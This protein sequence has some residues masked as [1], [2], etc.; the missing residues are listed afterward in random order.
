MTYDPDDMS[1]IYG[2]A[3]RFLKSTLGRWRSQLPELWEDAYQEG[4]IQVWRDVEAGVSPKLKILR[5]A[6]MASERFLH[7]NGENF[8]GRQRKSREGISRNSGTREKVEIFLEEY[9]PVHGWVYPASK[10]V[11]EAI[12]ITRENA[13]QHLKNIREGRGDHMVYRADGRMDWNY[14]KTHSIE[15]LMTSTSSSGTSNRH[16]SDSSEVER[17]QFSWEA[18]LIADVDVLEMLKKLTPAHQEILY[19]HLFEGYT[20]TEVARLNGVEKNPNSIGG[21]TLRAALN[22]IRMLIAPYEGECSVGHKRSPETSVVK[23]RVDGFY[24]RICTVC[25]KNGGGDKSLV[26]KKPMGRKIKT[27]CPKGHLKD[28]VDSHGRFRC[29]QCRAEAQRRYTAKKRAQDDSSE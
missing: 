29:S 14:Y 21:K 27:H 24:I 25:R 7:R 22:Q 4:M 9:M 10:V 1:N 20:A 5:R 28:Q 2:E 11:A 8:F 18:D 26:A 12:G 17:F 6:T 16:W 3:E 13:S 23:K 15:T 19:L